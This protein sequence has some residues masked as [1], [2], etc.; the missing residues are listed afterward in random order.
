MEA[1]FPV[2][3]RIGAIPMGRNLTGG[4]AFLSWDGPW[5]SE[6][7]AE[8]SVDPDASCKLQYC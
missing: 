1:L 4:W 8:A 3:Y 5:L 6:Q 7:S 2:E